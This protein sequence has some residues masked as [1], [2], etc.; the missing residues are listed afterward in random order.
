ML[1]KRGRYSG[2]R[3][4]QGG[5]RMRRLSVMGV[6][7]MIALALVGC[8]K[9]AEQA[10]GTASDSLLAANPVE[11]PQSGITPQTEYQQP[12]QPKEKAPEAPAPP[13]HAARKPTSRPR[14]ENPSPPAPAAAPGVTMPTGTGINISVNAQI[15]SETAQSGD[16]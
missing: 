16:N 11:P 6:A 8:S 13:A 14:T 15:S 10:A 2:A 7:L 3:A 5:M 12:E 1:S 4:G 9:K